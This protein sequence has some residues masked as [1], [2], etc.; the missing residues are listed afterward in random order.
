MCAEE[1]LER[2]GLGIAQ[3]GELGRDMA[4][5]AVVL[6]E[7]RPALGVV[8]NGGISVVGE[9]IGE[10]VESIEWRH[11]IQ[12]GLV[13]RH[14]L[15]GALLRESAQGIVAPMRAEISQGAD[16][17]V[18]VCDIE[19]VTAIVGEG[20]HPRGAPAAARRRGTEGAALSPRDQALGDER[21]QVPPH[22]GGAA[23]QRARKLGGS[24]RS[25][26][27][28]RACH[29]LSTRPREFHTHSVS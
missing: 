3:L 12:G 24:R 28:E 21:V 11:G 7:L 22:H 18:V 13:A 6:A 25:A 4:H 26:L 29:P 20:E 23:A 2:V 8:R 10:R 27:E 5:R 17:E 16:R 15:V 19:Y 14:H 9:A 1:S